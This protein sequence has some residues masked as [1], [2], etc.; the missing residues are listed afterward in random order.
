MYLSSPAR[1]ADVDIDG[2]TITEEQDLLYSNA[3]IA[4]AVNDFL[5]NPVKRRADLPILS[6]ERFQAIAK[7]LTKTEDVRSWRQRGWQ[8]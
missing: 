1:A 2:L 3:P 5:A 6:I 7:L 8:R 4:K